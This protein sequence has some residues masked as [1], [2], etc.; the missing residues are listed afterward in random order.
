MERFSAEAQPKLTSASATSLDPANF[1]E[2]FHSSPAAASREKYRYPVAG[3]MKPVQSVAAATDAYA[4]SLDQ[5]N[6]ANLN[7]HLVAD[8]VVPE[9]PTD[10]LMKPVAASRFI[11]IKKKGGF[12]MRCAQRTSAQHR[13]GAIED[14]AATVPVIGTTASLPYDCCGG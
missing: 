8:R 10:P 9:F 2:T 12:A 6:A 5:A 7:D 1:T 13:G 11:R 14:A 3:W 4:A